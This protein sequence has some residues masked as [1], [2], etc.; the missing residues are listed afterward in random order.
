MD[1]ND[2]LHN[3]GRCVRDTQ[4][5]GHCYS[6]EYRYKPKPQPPM[7]VKLAEWLYERGMASATDVQDAYQTRQNA[8][9]APPD[10]LDGETIEK[11]WKGMPSASCKALL[12]MYYVKRKPPAWISRGLSVDFDRELMVAQAAIQIELDR[13]EK[14]ARKAFL[15]ASIVRFGMV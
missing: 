12:R 11:A 1:I 10:W 7:T 8:R 15:N 6:I 13:H 9:Y 14:Y 4:R 3:W 5:Q 2:R